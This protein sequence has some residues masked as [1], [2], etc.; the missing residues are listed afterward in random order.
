MLGLGNLW[1]VIPLPEVE[2]QEEKHFQEKSVLLW[3]C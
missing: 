3:K 1:M 2:M